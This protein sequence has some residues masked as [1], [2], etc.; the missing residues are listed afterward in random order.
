MSVKGVLLDFN[1]TLFFD[2]H[3]HE[4]TWKAISKELRGY[5]MSDEELRDHM[6]GKNN[7]KVITYIVGKSIDDEENK[8]YSL[9]KEA[10]YREMC[11]AHPELFHLAKGVEVFLDQLVEKKIPF[12]IASA[13]IKE[14]IDFFVEKFHLDHW[15]DPARIVYDDG[16][17]PTKVEM[18]R[19]A[20]RRIQADVTQCLVLEDS[21]S[22]IQFAQDAGACSIIAVDSGKDRSKYEQFPYLTAIIDDFTSFPW[23]SIK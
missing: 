4:L 20:A 6:H 15:L 21:V 13:S 9:K 7:D 12:T 2:S 10:M 11:E 17:Y 18:F 3:Y 14:N 1:G 23:E 16:S 22:G 5:E 8:R 19:E